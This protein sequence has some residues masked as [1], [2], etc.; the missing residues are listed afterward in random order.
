MRLED[1]RGGIR[2]EDF[3]LI[4]HDGS[5]NDDFFGNGG[6]PATLRHMGL[7][8]GNRQVTQTCSSGRPQVQPRTELV[9]QLS[10]RTGDVSGHSSAFLVDYV[11]DQRD[12]TLRIAM[13]YSFCGHDNDLPVSCP[14]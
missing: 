12:R 1:P 8:E 7:S 14:D 2:L 5:S 13:A 3:A 6:D 9:L 11:T 4:P 10:H